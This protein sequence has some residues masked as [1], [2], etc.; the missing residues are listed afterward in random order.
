M[1]RSKASRASTSAAREVQYRLAAVPSG[2]AISRTFAYRPAWNSHSRVGVR[3]SGGG[4]AFAFSRS[5][6]AQ[7][8]CPLRS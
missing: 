2:R 3:Q 6:A 1:R 4:T 8:A 5:T 7:S